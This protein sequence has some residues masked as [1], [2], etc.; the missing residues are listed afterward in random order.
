M[1]ADAVDV[2]AKGPYRARC[3][4]TTPYARLSGCCPNTRLVSFHC[5]PAGAHVFDMFAVCIVQRAHQGRSGGVWKT[6]SVTGWTRRDMR[7]AKLPNALSAAGGT[8]ILA[9]RCWLLCQNRSLSSGAAFTFYIL[10]YNVL[11]ITFNAYAMNLHLFVMY[12]ICFVLSI[13]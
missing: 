3:P 4:L 6:P 7:L 8:A 12:A 11:G 2:P 10:S 9:C 13:A 1:A 5:A